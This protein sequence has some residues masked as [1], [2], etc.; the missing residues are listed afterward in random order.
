MLYTFVYCIVPFTNEVRLISMHFT[1]VYQHFSWLER[2]LTLSLFIW[3]PQLHVIFNSFVHS[4][5]KFNYIPC[6][7]LGVWNENNKAWF[8]T[9]HKGLFKIVNLKGYGSSQEEINYFRKGFIAVL[10]KEVSAMLRFFNIFCP[11][12]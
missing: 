8:L 6:T 9:Y 10:S 4:V 12:Q 3:F 11:I 5:L 2:P 1:E 7:I